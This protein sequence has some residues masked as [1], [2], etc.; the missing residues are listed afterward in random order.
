MISRLE[1]F[2]HHLLEAGRSSVLNIIP[3]FCKDTSTRNRSIRILATPDFRT[4]E[5][6]FAEVSC[7]IKQKGR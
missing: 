6:G 1:R 4:K 5:Y 7:N 3:P 2:N